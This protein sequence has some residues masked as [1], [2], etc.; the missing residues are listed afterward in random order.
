MG[1][2]RGLELECESEKLIERSHARGSMKWRTERRIIR[3]LVLGRQPNDLHRYCHV[4]QFGLNELVAAIR[5]DV[6]SIASVHTASRILMN[7]HVKFSTGTA[8]ASLILRFQR[9]GTL[10]G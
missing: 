5:E 4:L 3:G 10:L 6:S 1:L 9:N 2:A 8:Q 7:R